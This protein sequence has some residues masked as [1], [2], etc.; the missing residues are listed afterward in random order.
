MERN[1]VGRSSSGGLH[2]KWRK[3]AFVCLFCLSNIRSL[4]CLLSSSSMLG[5]VA[6]KGRK[7]PVMSPDYSRVVEVWGGSV[8]QE[9]QK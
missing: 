8:T 4:K 1:N 5:P 9:M 7:S 2:A 3:W 6:K